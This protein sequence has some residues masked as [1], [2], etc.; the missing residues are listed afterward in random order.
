MTRRGFGAL[1]KRKTSNVAAAREAV[2]R[3]A[4]G[5][6]PLPPTAKGL[7]LLGELAPA[8]KAP[9]LKLAADVPREA[10]TQAEAYD[11]F[12]KYGLP[13][14][15]TI[16]ANILGMWIGDAAGH[17]RTQAQIV[18]TAQIASSQRSIGM[19]D[20]TPDMVVTWQGRAFWIEFKRE[21][22]Q[23]NH[24]DDNQRREILMLLRS[25]CR[26]GVARSIA[27]AEALFDLWGVPLRARAPS[28]RSP[29]P[30]SS[31]ATVWPIE[32]D[33]LRDMILANT[34]RRLLQ[35]WGFASALPPL[36]GSLEEGGSTPGTKARA[37]SL[38]KTAGKKKAT[39]R[40]TETSPATTQNFSKAG[41]NVSTSRARA[42]GR[43][44]DLR[45]RRH[46]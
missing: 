19:R 3:L 43:S 44:N 10:Q 21:D 11:W 34:D 12:L 42:Q 22:G 35:L 32:G 5:Q 41:H 14:D 26:V 15:A 16:R 36:R 30:A 17:Q 31:R 9:K 23:F 4:S 40:A 45:V 6:V 20:G 18:R 1:F 24:I 37:K 29:K 27:E 39:S 46:S 25:G 2:E 7:P 33:R 28:Y 8:K 13:R 38:A